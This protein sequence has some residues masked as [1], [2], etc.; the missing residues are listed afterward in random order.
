ML[1]FTDAMA[2]GWFAERDGAPVDIAI[3][4]ATFR[5]VVVDQDTERVVFTYRPMFTYVGFVVVL[6]AVALSSLWAV[7]TRRGDR[8]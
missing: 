8:A 2:P 4:D 6:V 3:V 7:W 1:V 5:G